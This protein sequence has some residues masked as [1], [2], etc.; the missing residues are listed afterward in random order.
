MPLALRKMLIRPSLGNRRQGHALHC[1][2]QVVEDGS[3]S[4]VREGRTR[5]EVEMEGWNVAGRGVMGGKDN[6]REGWGQL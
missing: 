6:G 1:H 2:F 5:V 4:G 3:G